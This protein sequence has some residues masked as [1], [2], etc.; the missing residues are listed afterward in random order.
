M[1]APKEVI[2]SKFY[3]RLNLTKKEVNTSE[4]ASN[5]IAKQFRVAFKY[6]QDNKGGS[7]EERKT[8]NLA[9]N[10]LTNTERRRKYDEALAKYNLSDGNYK[11]PDYL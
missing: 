9:R 7:A 10:V 8:I 2:N 4:D 5:L 1:K 6:A 3:E 11:D